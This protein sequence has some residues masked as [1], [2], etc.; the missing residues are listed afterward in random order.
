MVFPPPNSSNHSLQ[1]IL[2]ITGKQSGSIYLHES[3]WFY[4]SAWIFLFNRPLSALH[5]QDKQPFSSWNSLL[6]SGRTSSSDSLSELFFPSADTAAAIIRISA[7]KGS[8]GVFSW[9]SCKP[10]L[11]VQLDCMETAVCLCYNLTERKHLLACATTWLKG[12][13]SWPVLQLDWKETFLGLC[14]NLTARKQLFT[15][16][17][18]WL[19]GTDSS[20]PVLQFDRTETAVQLCYNLSAW[21]WQLFTCATTWLQENSSLSVLQLDCMG[22]ALHLCYNLTAWEQ[23]FTC[24]TI[25]LHE[26]SSSPVL[27]LDCI[28]L[29]ALHLCY[30]LTA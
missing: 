3:A 18:T 17:T 4:L 1:T 24:A 5:R 29:T 23:L 19:H 25:W 8:A 16:A 30:I 26:N 14:Y 6:I 10:T 20:P 9:I 15:C 22:S 27:H 11:Q 2:W 28:E 21:N 13:I 12:N 7:S